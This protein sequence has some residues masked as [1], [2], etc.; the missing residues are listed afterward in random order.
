MIIKVHHGKEH[1]AV[2]AASSWSH[3]NCIQGMEIQPVEYGVTF[4]YGKS[5]GIK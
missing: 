3:C 2:W 4:C 5:S 1:M